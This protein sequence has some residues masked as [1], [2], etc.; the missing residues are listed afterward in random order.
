ML[1][2]KTEVGCF[3]W[4]KYDSED[5]NGD[6]SDAKYEQ[7]S[8]G[9]AKQAREQTNPQEWYISKIEQINPRF[10]ELVIQL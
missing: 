10:S 7:V 9:I 4:I 3:T 8:N 2:C 1:D 5:N 6:I